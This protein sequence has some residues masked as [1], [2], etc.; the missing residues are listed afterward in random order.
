MVHWEDLGWRTFD[1][2]PFDTDIWRSLIEKNDIYTLPFPCRR[3]AEGWI[4][5]ATGRV[6]EVEPSH[7]RSCSES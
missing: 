7:W 4:N 5:A 2:A 6:V 1:T 3:T